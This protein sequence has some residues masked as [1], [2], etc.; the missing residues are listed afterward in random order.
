M[1]D[2]CLGTA[3]PVLLTVNPEPVVATTLDRTVCSNEATGLVFNTNGLSVAATMYNL[4]SVTPSAGV[5]ADVGN[6]TFPSTG[7]DTMAATDL[8]T[9]TTGAVGFVDYVVEGISAVGCE[10]EQQ[11]IR[12]TINAQPVLA[13]NLNA[14][15][16]SDDPSGITLG[17]ATGSFPAVTYNITAIN[18]PDALVQSAG[19]TTV[20]G[21][22]FTA[23]EIADDAFT[24]TGTDSFVEYTIA[25]VSADGCVGD[26]VVVILS[27]LIRPEIVVVPELN[28]CDDAVDGSDTNG[29][30]RFDLTDRATDILNGQT[31]VR[32][33]LF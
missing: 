28:V 31:N 12:V 26:E 29:F 20:V 3:Q 17:V 2:G 14:A 21:V 1:S 5:T 27:I 15:V 10:G 4:V 16:C 7:L 25:P 18:N 6:V 30:V 32:F 9:N 19:G 8:F 23:A 22:G 33:G 24:N 11:I 13:T